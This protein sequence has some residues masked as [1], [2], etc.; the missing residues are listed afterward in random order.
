MQKDSTR[1]DNGEMKAARE[2]GLQTLRCLPGIEETD[3]GGRGEGAGGAGK[4]VGAAKMR[5]NEESA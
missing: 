3:A 4:V 2:E 1:E 5:Q